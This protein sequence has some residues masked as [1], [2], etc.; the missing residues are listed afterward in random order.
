MGELNPVWNSR[1]AT[2]YVSVSAKFQC[3]CISFK[4]T[5]EN[6]RAWEQN[7]HLHGVSFLKIGTD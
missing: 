7:L 1:K 3:F 5:D 6:S 4:V 2:L